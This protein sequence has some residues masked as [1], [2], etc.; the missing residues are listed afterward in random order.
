MS[1]RCWPS[2]SGVT[3]SVLVATAIRVVRRTLAS[4][5]TMKRS[6]GPIFSLAG[7]HT[8]TTST[9]AHVVRTRSLS[10]SPSRV[11]GRCRPGVS[12]RISCASS[13]CTM[14]RTTL[15]VVCGLDGRDDDL[16]ARPARWSASTCPRW[17]GRRTTR[18]RCG[19]PPGACVERAR[20]GDPGQV[21][22]VVQ[23]VVVLVVLVRSSS[24]STGSSRSSCWSSCSS[25]IARLSL[26]RRSRPRSAR[27]SS[28]P[29]CPR[30]RWVPGSTARGCRAGG[31]APVAHHV[32]VAGREPDLAH[33]VLADRPHLGGLPGHPEVALA[34]G[35]VDA[36]D[37]LGQRALP[38]R[39]RGEPGDLR[40]GGQVAGSGRRAPPPGRTSAGRGGTRAMRAIA[41]MAVRSPTSSSQ[42]AP[43]GGANDALGSVIVTVSPTQ[44]RM[45][46]SVTRPTSWTTTSRV[47]SPSR[48]DRTV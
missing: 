11:R 9:S 46:H 7:K 13:R 35:P 47:S 24:I 19:S 29:P 28:L 17:A 10:R 8:A 39:R 15:R 16:L 1:S 27:H 12:T 43:G 3:R 4:S 6:P 44:S 30:A 34:L 45:A 33:Q 48:S 18:S 22:V 41:G 2:C 40:V 36:L 23:L 21:E 25:A 37:D 20:R 5:L 38:R 32:V 42:A 14:P 31:R 26:P